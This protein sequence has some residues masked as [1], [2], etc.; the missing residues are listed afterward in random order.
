MKHNN[1]EKQIHEHQHIEITRLNMSIK[2]T[3][4]HKYPPVSKYPQRLKFFHYWIILM[5]QCFNFWVVH[6]SRHNYKIISTQRSLAQNAHPLTQSI[7]EPHLSIRWMI[8]LSVHFRKRV[9]VIHQLTFQC[10]VALKGII[11]ENRNHKY[12]SKVY[13]SLFLWILK[14]GFYGQS[15]T[16]GYW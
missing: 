4:Q 7:C 8:I 9:A 15:L 16:R 1:K 14:R 10:H 11:Y 6:F 5:L 2:C 3:R 13:C 12:W